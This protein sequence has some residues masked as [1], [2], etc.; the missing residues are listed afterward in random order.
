MKLCYLD[1]EFNGVSEPKLNLVSVAAVCTDGPN[2]ITYK[3]EWWLHRN[4]RSKKEARNFFAK[5]IAEGYTFVA[6]VMEAE[7]RSLLSLF[8][9][10]KGWLKD[11]KAIDIYLE[12]RNLLNHNHEYAYGLQYLKGKEIKTTP[13]P[14]K[15]MRDDSEDDNEAHHKPEYSLAAATFKMLGVKI[16]TEEKT[17]ARDIIIRSNADEIDANA[18]RILKYNV[19]DIEYLPK[20]L[21]KLRSVITQSAGISTKEWIG[22]ALTRGDYAVRTARMLELGY[23]VNLEK[24]EKFTS[25]IDQIL[26]SSVKQVLEEHP[27]AF[28]YAKKIGRWSLNEKEVRTWIESQNYPTWRKT[29]GG[30]TGVKKTSLSKDAFADYFSSESEGFGGAFYRHLKTKQSLNGFI[31]PKSAGLKTKKRFQDFVGSDGRVRPYF[32]IYGSQASRSQPGAVG[33]IPLKSHWM[34]NF[35][36]ARPGR[37]LAQ[38][39][40][41]AEEFLVAAVLSQ[42]KAMLRAYDSGDVYLAFGKS[43]GLI[44]EHGTKDTHKALRNV[45]KT[46]VLGI[47]YDLSARG[48]AP[49]LTQITK[50]DWTEDRAQE[51]IDLFYET[52]SDYGEWKREVQTEY[53]DA[54]MLT[55][56]DGWMMWG[57]NDNPRSVGNFQVQGLG[58]VIMR[59]AVAFAQD[60]GLDV[61][62][63]LHDSLMIE[64][65]AYDVSQM[66]S[67]RDCMAAAAAEVFKP[68]GDFIPIE[69]SGEAWSSDYAATPPPSIAGFHYMSEYSDAKGGKDLERYRKFF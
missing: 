23:P 20:L 24:I 29:S 69:L 19:S 58:A 17:A 30:K 27:K 6:F 52:Y 33:F 26:D 59:K 12:Y 9:D 57:D 13:P 10:D 11:F 44:P 48:L 18:E 14:P 67:L 64:T 54:G 1:A 22:H 25:N 35:I 3:R 38:W 5:I 16:D 46:C 39:D 15:W 32:G 68:Y 28:R 53:R 2:N 61:L 66:V 31:E 21:N 7:A 55:L 42:D 56:Q 4:E 41:S 45:C 8:G 43:A 63:T 51:L 60:A 36:E 62:L 47:S 34:R 50:E 65:D 37:A 40:Y 49:R